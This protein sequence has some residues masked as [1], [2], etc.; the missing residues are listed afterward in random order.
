MPCG[1][2]QRVADLAGGVDEVQASHWPKDGELTALLDR[3]RGLSALSLDVC[4]GV[5]GASGERIRLLHSH[6]MT[7]L[8]WDRH[9]GHASSYDVVALG[10]NYLVGVQRADRKRLLGR[11]DLP[12]ALAG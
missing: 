6:G 8:T 2:P 5:R 11:V 4:V 1:G 3:P 7:T 12:V 10:L 9:R